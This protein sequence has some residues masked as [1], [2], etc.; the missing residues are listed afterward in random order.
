M[1]DDPYSYGGF[2]ETIDRRPWTTATRRRRCTREGQARR[3][4]YL[5]ATYGFGSNQAPSFTDKVLR[6]FF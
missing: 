3:V 2:A 5:V 4:S 1:D 6:L